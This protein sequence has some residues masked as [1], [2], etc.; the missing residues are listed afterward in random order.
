MKQINVDTIPSIVDSEE[1]DYYDREVMN[2][3]IQ[4]EVEGGSEFETESEEEGEISKSSDEEREVSAPPKKKAKSQESG[5]TDELLNHLL[6]EKLKAM[7]PEE[8]KQMLE[9][10][11]IEKDPE[12]VVTLVKEVNNGRGVVTVKSPSESTLYRP[13]FTQRIADE[14]SPQ[15]AVRSPSGEILNKATVR[16]AVNNNSSHELIGKISEFL[17]SIQKEQGKGEEFTEPRSNQIRSE[18]HIPQIDSVKERAE[19]SV[20]EAEKFRASIEPPKKGRCYEQEDS[21]YNLPSGTSAQLTDDDFFHLTCHIDEHL[22]EKMERGKYIDLE[23]L[24]P[25]SGKGDDRL[26]WVHREGSTFLAP[27]LQ[28]DGKIN[29][30]K[31]WD[32]AF[33]IFATFYCGANPNRAKEIWQYVNVIHTAAAAYNWDNVYNYDVT[34]RHLME[35]NPSRSWAVTYTHMWNLSLK[36]PLTKNNWFNRGSFGSSGSTGFLSNH[37]NHAQNDRSPAVGSSGAV[38]KKPSYCWSWN[39]GEKCKFG[40]KC[41]FIERCSYCDSSNHGLHECV[42]AKKQKGSKNSESLSS[43]ATATESVN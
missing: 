41:H 36:D 28:R 23:K 20:V 29:N 4:V 8:I 12:R 3:G 27:V 30:V 9:D 40:A 17:E 35:F 38:K 14:L 19:H 7:T 10:K 32:Q 43:V 16:N 22:R 33:R 34:F 15:I 18:I 11:G 26:E 25:K 31:K 6:K 13:I 5:G 37:N 21:L 24:L 1:L 42:K 39:K 2:D